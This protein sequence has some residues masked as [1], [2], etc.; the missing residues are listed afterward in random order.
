MPFVQ[1]I[2][3]K[4]IYDNYCPSGTEKGIVVI[5]FFVDGAVLRNLVQKYVEKTGVVPTGMLSP[6]T[7]VYNNR[8]KRRKSWCSD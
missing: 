3:D 8:V 1:Y 6:A 4:A 5:F 7:K 2:F